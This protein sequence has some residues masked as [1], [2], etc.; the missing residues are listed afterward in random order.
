[1]VSA[2][3][4][5]QIA[6]SVVEIPLAAG[7]A[8]IIARLRLRIHSELRQHPAANIIVMEVATEA[9]MRKLDFARAKDLARSTDRI[10][11]R[12]VEILVIGD[13]G[14]EFARK[15]LGIDRRLLRPGVARQ[16]GEVRE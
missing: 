14:S 6:I 16:P 2:V 11:L 10:I 12:M 1:M 7:G 13:V 3:R 15:I 9:E 4:L 5:G 8:G